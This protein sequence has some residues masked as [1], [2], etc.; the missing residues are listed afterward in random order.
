MLF[1]FVLK[2]LR[3]LGVTSLWTLESI[4]CTTPSLLSTMPHYAALGQCNVFVWL[5]HSAPVCC[6]INWSAGVT[7]TGPG[8]V[9][10]K[11]SS[12]CVHITHITHITHPPHLGQILSDIK[13]LTSHCSLWKIDSLNIYEFKN[14]Y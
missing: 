8:R 3:V 5:Q 14:V 1:N 9:L 7:K 2:A 10:P 12:K 13:L 11:L 4:V 6:I